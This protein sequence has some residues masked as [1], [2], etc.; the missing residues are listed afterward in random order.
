MALL[1]DY[2]FRWGPMEITRVAIVETE[3]R[4]LEVRTP[5][6]ALSIY[7]SLKGNSVRV[8]KDGIELIPKEKEDNG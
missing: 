2:G 8:F 7:V 1:T 3:R 4:V 5:S 6:T